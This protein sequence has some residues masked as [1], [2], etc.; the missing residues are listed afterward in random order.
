MRNGN[1]GY[2]PDYSSQHY[3]M[4]FNRQS[5]ITGTWSQTHYVDAEINRIPRPAYVVA[6]LALASIVLCAF[7]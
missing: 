3:T 7:I 6:V 5:R 2:L 4:R 1:W